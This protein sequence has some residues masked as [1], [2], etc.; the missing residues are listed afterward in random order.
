MEKSHVSLCDQW[1][2]FIERVISWSNVSVT[3]RRE[4]EKERDQQADEYS[5]RKQTSIEKKT[6]T[7]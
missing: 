3:L 6:S 4:T 1:N 2:T 5:E 7:Y